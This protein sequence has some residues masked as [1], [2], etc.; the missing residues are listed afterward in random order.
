MTDRSLLVVSHKTKRH[1]LKGTLR[2]LQA[3]GVRLLGVVTDQLSQG[4]DSYYY[5]YYY[6]T[7]ASGRDAVRS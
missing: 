6:D 3:A 2:N 4:G 7:T 5:Y 1:M